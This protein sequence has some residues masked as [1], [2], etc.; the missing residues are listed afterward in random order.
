M[1]SPSRAS[2]AARADVGAADRATEAVDPWQRV[3][4]VSVTHLSGAVIG[5]CVASVRRAAQ[6]IV[7]DNA[8]DDDTATVVERTAPEAIIVR[9][10]V[11]LGYGNGAN[12]G[13]VQ[14]LGEFALLVNPDA[15]L[16]SGCVDALVAAADRFPEAA[17]FG[18]RIL[19]PDGSVELSHDVEMFDHRRYG[20]RRD[21]APP[22]GDC[23]AE[24]LSGAV[25]LLRMA[26]LRQVGFFDPQIFLYYDD[27]DMCLRLRQAGYVLLHVPSA[28][29]EHVGG[30]SVRPSAGYHWGK[31][32][33]SGW[34]RLYIEKKYHGAAAMLGVAARQLPR[35]A[36]KA[37]WYALVLDP[38]KAWRDAARFCGAASYVLGVPASKTVP[39]TRPPDGIESESA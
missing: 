19:N 37:V 4:V 35:F 3:A 20:K 27:D 12:Q 13:L 31:F 26:A 11:N 25:V 24:R 29:A 17:M 30:G 23:C 15:V 28:V 8:S 32:W 22:E 16:R 6:I 1:I 10:D 2:L 36:A 14:V 5:A 38:R 9:N 33:H 7:V 34:S 18:P 21:E 39:H